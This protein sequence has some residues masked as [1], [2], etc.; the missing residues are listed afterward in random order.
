MGHI[1]ND[2][3]VAVDLEKIEAV[4]QWPLPKSSKQLRG[5]LGLTGYY[6]RFVR[7]YASWIA[8]LTQLL[9]K[10]A[11]IWSEQ[12][13]KAFE[14]LKH[15]LTT[16]PVLSLP[17]FKEQFTVQTDASGIGI[18]AVLS[19]SNKPIAFFSKLLPPSIRPTSAYNRELCAV[20]HAVLKWRHIC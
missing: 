17:N 12:A 10:D 9:R 13:T 15:A 14:K 7:N 19:Q 3:G 11:F 6:R 4:V 5:F 8:P 20:V 18:G 2:R 1:I 16:T